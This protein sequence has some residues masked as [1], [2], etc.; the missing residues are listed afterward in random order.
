[1]ANAKG[2][3]TI[4]RVE[5]DG[6]KYSVDVKRAESWTAAR[7]IAAMNS[8]DDEAKR[9]SLAITFADFILGDE[10]EKVVKACGGE[11][12]RAEDVLTLAYKIIEAASKN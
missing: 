10:M 5:V 9:G 3:S 4:K 8:T 12:A 2:N 11:D 6:K 1:M 7:M